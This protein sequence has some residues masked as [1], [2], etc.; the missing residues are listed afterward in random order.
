MR[1]LSSELRLSCPVAVQAHFLLSL[2][3]GE[4]HK[5]GEGGWGGGNCSKIKLLNNIM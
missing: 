5:Y 2:R 1:H 3:E 4:V